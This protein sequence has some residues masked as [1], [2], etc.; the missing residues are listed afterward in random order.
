M[1]LSVRPGADAKVQDGD[2]DVPVVGSLCKL[3]MGPRELR[4]LALFSETAVSPNS[5]HNQSS[6]RVFSGHR[7]N[8]SDPSF[9][10]M[11]C[12]R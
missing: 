9:G 10:I 12:P 8:C 6:L 1:Q 2:E 7:L 5:R 11:Y 4:R 3:S